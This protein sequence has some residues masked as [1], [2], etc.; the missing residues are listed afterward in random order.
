MA[1]FLALPE[2]HREEVT[3][4]RFSWRVLFLAGPLA[5]CL[6]RYQLSA[7][8]QVSPSHH[9]TPPR[10][11]PSHLYRHYKHHKIQQNINYRFLPSLGVKSVLDN[12]Y[13]RI[14]YRLLL[15]AADVWVERQ[16]QMQ[17]QMRERMVSMQVARAR[18]LLY[19][20]GSFY[21]LAALGMIAGFRRTRK[22]GV[23]APLLPLSFIGGYQADMA[24]GNKLH[25]IR[26]EA[27][28]I[29]QYEMD[30]LELPCGLPS[31]SSIDQAR[32]DNDEKKKLH[33]A[34]PPI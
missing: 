28:N 15:F 2:K 30:L 10:A 21:I 3:M 25:R 7:V 33:P 27:E 32:L 11:R 9:H 29:M 14:N 19:W 20:F 18:E 13:E 26:G 23:L 17:N 4:Y 22:P 34:V 12:G 6:G 24:Y 31:A 5:Y 8:G 1:W 16:I